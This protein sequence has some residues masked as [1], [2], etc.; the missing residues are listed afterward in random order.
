MQTV[1]T[2]YKPVNYNDDSRYPVDD[3]NRNHDPSPFPIRDIP[4]LEVPQDIISRNRARSG[5]RR[6]V[7]TRTGPVDDSVASEG[8][9][10]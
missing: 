1:S 4:D 7:G 2:F 6:R 3:D 5:G 9:A 8:D 10:A